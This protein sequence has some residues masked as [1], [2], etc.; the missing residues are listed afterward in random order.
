M[1]RRYS[2]L[3]RSILV[4]VIAMSALAG[5]SSVRIGYNHL[6]GLAEWT[7]DRYFDLDEEQTKAFRTRFQKLHQWHRYD[8][9]PDYANFLAEA[10]ARFERG[11]TPEDAHWFIEGVRQ[12]YI[13]LVEHSADDAAAILLTI[14]PAQLEFLQARLDRVNERFAREFRIGSSLADQRSATVQRTIENCRDWFGSL[15]VAQ[16]EMIVAAIERMDMIGPLRQQD[17]IRR[18]REFLALMQLRGE[19]A[20]FR[21]KLKDWFIHWQAGRSPE[22]QRAFEVSMKQRI[23]LALE[24]D[25]SLTPHQRTMAASRLQDYIDDFRA[26]S[27]RT[28]VQA[29]VADEE[30]ASSKP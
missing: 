29:A 30:P 21:A 22:Y 19:P 28:G 13:I 10:R 11:L 20:V 4:A 7:A 9:L 24:I 3:A 26:L 6:E 17:R 23:A 15:S 8:Q 25:R 18:Q 27:R 14:T 16:E 5:C 2:S 12:R 1:I